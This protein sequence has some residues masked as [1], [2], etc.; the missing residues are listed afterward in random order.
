MRG[1]NSP[2]LASP[3][4]C[5]A[6]RLTAW[7]CAAI[8][9]PVGCDGAV[10]RV[11][12]P[13]QLVAIAVAGLREAMEQQYLHRRCPP[14]AS[15]KV[16]NRVLSAAEEKRTWHDARAPTPCHSPVRQLD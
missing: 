15:I 7:S 1:S 11:R 10:A 12:E 8:A 16:T 6:S 4:C 5:G 3:N 2:S 13:R 9:A 14:A